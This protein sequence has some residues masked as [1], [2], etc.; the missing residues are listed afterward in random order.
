MIRNTECHHFIQ[1]ANTMLPSLPTRW[2][3]SGPEKSNP[4]PI[5]MAITLGVSGH[6]QRIWLRENFIMKPDVSFTVTANLNAGIIT[7]AG[8]DRDVK[9]MHLYPAGTTD[10]QQGK[11]APDKN[12]ELIK[13]DNS[14]LTAD[15]LP[16][17]MMYS[18]ISGMAS[19]MNGGKNIV[20]QTGMRTQ[21]R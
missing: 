1:K 15:V 16:D 8:T 6:T 7:Y 20:V 17:L 19:A 10:R 4:E 14:T 3:T 12:L 13:C 18:S 21:V 9:A 11:P 2:L 5:D